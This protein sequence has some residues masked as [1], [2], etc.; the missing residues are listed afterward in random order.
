MRYIVEPSPQ[1]V[2]ESAAPFVRPSF[3]LAPTGPKPVG[4]R[5]DDVNIATDNAKEAA[6]AAAQYLRTWWAAIASGSRNRWRGRGL[7]R[8]KEVGVDEQFW[9]CC[10]GNRTSC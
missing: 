9:H 2:M 7:E 4:I 3:P 6:R 1:G 5:Q 10:P 8:M